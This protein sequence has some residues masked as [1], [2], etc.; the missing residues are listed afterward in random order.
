MLVENERL[1]AACAS[2]A[3]EEVR[4]LV[5]AG[6]RRAGIAGRLIEG[7]RASAVT[8][9]REAAIFYMSAII[10]ARTGEAPPDPL[11][12]AD[13]LAR[14]RAVAGDPL[15]GG[16]PDGH[17]AFLDL[18][19]APDPRAIERR[20]PTEARALGEAARAIVRALGRLVEPRG[21]DEI[22][23]IRRARLAT[24][25]AAA[26]A[27]VAWVT[28]RAATHRTKLGLHK[29]VTTSGSR[30]GATSPPETA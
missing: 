2:G 6:R 29:P 1:A 18:L 16:T 17:A 30:P 10:A 14:F 21:V 19:G 20:P 3:R 7:H 25:G 15:P 12:G 24:I 26:L 23:F 9:Y 5:D 28:V 4:A 8:L 11:G 27:L 13:V 22:R